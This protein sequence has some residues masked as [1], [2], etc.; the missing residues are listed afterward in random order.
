AQRPHLILLDI[1]MPALKGDEV[2]QEIRKK[3]LRSPVIIMTAMASYE[4][5]VSLTRAGACDYLTKPIGPQDLIHRIKRALVLETT[6]AKLEATEKELTALKIKYDELLR[7]KVPRFK[8]LLK[9]KHIQKQPKVF[10]VHGRDS[11]AKLELKN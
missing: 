7:A 1:M 3:G 2:I 8:T 10:I 11:H 4:S 6:G 5:A 9:N